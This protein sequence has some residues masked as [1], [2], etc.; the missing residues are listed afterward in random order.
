MSRFGRPLAT[1]G[2]MITATWFIVLSAR[3]ADGCRPTGAR[4]LHDARIVRP[5]HAA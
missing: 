4:R 1:P 3:R 2:P 5:R